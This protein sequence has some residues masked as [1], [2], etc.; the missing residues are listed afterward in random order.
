MVELGLVLAVL[1]GIALG[2]LGGGGSILAVPILVYA[3][4]FDTKEA[5]AASLAVVG[6]TSLFGAIEHWRGGCLQYRAALIFGPIT[7]VGAYLGA[8]L[9]GF[10]SGN[11]QLSMF[12]V[13]M[14]LAAIFMFMNGVSDDATEHVSKDSVWR[15]L[16]RFSLPGMAVG[17]LTGVV[18]VGGGFLIV[19]ALVL[20]AG[21]PMRQAVG[22]SLPV[23]AMN[24]LAG[25][26]GYIGEV[27]IPWDFL[28]LFTA[29]AVLG[30]FTGAYLARI[31]PQHALKKSFAVF[32]VVMAAFILYESAGSIL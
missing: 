9:A 4:G 20:L 30:S 32:L 24:S 23:I 27:E 2:V 1:M 19:P 12:A 13:V 16:V 17:L 7:A 6:L 15:L 26:A 29:L 14:V 18:G 25:F 5:I 21:M 11:V 28:S 3:V 10:L 22:T 8:H 31:I